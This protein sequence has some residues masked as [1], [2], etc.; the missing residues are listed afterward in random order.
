VFRFVQKRNGIWRTLP[1]GTE[2]V[3][4]KWKQVLQEFK[5]K[6][7]RHYRW[8]QDRIIRTCTLERNTS[9]EDTQAVLREE[10]HHYN[11][12]QVHSTSGEVLAIRF[13]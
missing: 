6:V 4:P 5:V 3:D 11:Y 2:E 13:A 7:D 10:S 12:Q 8:L 9:M 1:L